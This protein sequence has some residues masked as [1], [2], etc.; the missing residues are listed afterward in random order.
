MPEGF[1]FPSLRPQ[2]FP[3]ESE[4][5]Y[6][7]VEQQVHQLE[8]Y[9]RYT[10]AWVRQQLVRSNPRNYDKTI[11]LLQSI[12]QHIELRVRQAY[13]LDLETKQ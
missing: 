6:P 8:Y 10:Q 2:V 11:R 13:C 3:P 5:S 1:T 4:H 12:T 9:Q 7:T